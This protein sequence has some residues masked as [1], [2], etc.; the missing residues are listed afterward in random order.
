VQSEV[1][2]MVKTHNIDVSDALQLLTILKGEHSGLI[3]QSASVLLTA[4]KGLAAA[5]AAVGVR[6]WNCAVEPAPPWA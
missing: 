5:A 1:D 4:D 3:H 2:Q 6:A